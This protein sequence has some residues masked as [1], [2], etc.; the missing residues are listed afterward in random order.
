MQ[1][2]KPG[3]GGRKSASD[4]GVDNRPGGGLVEH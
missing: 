2:V 3:I 1:Q 4:A